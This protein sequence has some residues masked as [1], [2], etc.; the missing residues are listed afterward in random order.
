MTVECKSQELHDCLARYP[1]NFSRLGKFKN[2]KVKLHINSSIKPVSVQQ[3]S[4]SSYLKEQADQAL[5]E[6]IKDDVIELHPEN[7]PVPWI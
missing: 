2:H 7:E 6:M 3:R 4:I 1:E 5:N